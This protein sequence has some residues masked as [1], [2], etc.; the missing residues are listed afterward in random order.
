VLQFPNSETIFQVAVFDEHGESEAVFAR[1]GEPGELELPGGIAVGNVSQ[2][3]VQERVARPFISTNPVAGPRQVEIF[4]E[5]LTIAPPSIESISATAVTSSSATLRARI[6]PNNRATSFWFEYGL[7]DC[8]VSVCTKVPLEGAPLGEGRRGVVVS[9]AIGGLSP[10]TTYHIRAVAENDLGRVEG[11][12]KVFTTQGGT[13][14]F[15]LSDSRVW[16]M[17]SPPRKF[18]GTVV[19][20]AIAAIQASH[21]GD[22]L[23]YASRGPIVEEPESNR[24]VDIATVLGKRGADGRWSTTDLTPRHTVASTAS[25]PTAYQL[26]SPDLAKA[27]LEPTDKT[28]LS[29]DA[30]EETPY[31]WTD[32]EPPLFTPLVNPSNVP[33]GTEF[34]S[35]PGG[36]EDLVRLEGGSPDLSHIVLQSEVPL[37]QGAQPGSIYMWANGQLKPLSELPEEEGGNV[38]QAILGSG[39]GSVRHAVSEDGSRVFWAPTHEY[40][41]VGNKLPK[42]FMRDTSTE[43]TSRLDVVQPGASGSGPEL[44]AFNIASGDGQVV[45]F[46]DSQQLTED[47]SPNGRDLYRC[48]IGDVAG[49]LGC[50]DLTDISAPLQG[51]GESAEVPDQVPAASDDGSRVYFVARAILDETQNDQGGSAEAGMP[52]LYVWHEGQGVQFIATL[53]KRDYLVWGG[54]GSSNSVG[55]AERISAAA[56][57]S[58]RFFAFT[59]DRSLT[60]YENHNEADQPASEVFV[61]DAEASGGHLTCLSCNPTGAAAVGQRIPDST[62]LYPP[63]RGELWSGKWV[64]ATLPEAST[65]RLVGRS[66]YHPRTALDNGRVFFN[67][68]EAL[69][70][71][72]SN[73]DWDV[74]QYQPVGLGTCTETSNSATV[75][76]VHEGCVG[77]VSSGSTGGDVGFL[78]A[79]ASGN[80][81]FFLSRA[82]LSALDTD[83]E[84]DVYDARVDGIAV[85]RNLG[86]E[87]AGEACRPA[88]TPPAEQASASESFQGMGTPIVCRKG[89]R[90][91]R[92]N[93]KTLCVHRRHNKHKHHH[94]RQGSKTGR[95]G[96]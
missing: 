63:D 4:D 52:N 95:A 40:D 56:S 64:A 83:D 66:F 65:S 89:Q 28:P 30:S 75:S 49:S 7:A 41:T 13:L 57:P 87:C 69:V 9:Q 92:K 43:V 37:S 36:K 8:S 73:G 25:V 94:K 2:V 72:D 22:K 44:P 81:A 53:A 78:D 38:V 6:N 17:V 42:L 35:K 88:L 48:E 58:G 50:A 31:L 33:A 91:V 80:D 54:L 60:D 23:V 70:P 59:S 10:E 29:P 20:G 3:G 26:F 79:S 51:S 15:S 21:S 32:G 68:V 14:G 85:E 93:G 12:D 45:F 18:A 61:Y 71:A 76:R 24:L 84:F 34:G 39:Q 46:T 55:F 90:K 47:A 77:L 11:P 19:S 27:G 74:Y 96:R 67:S 16:E 62:F 5:E 86:Q 1:S 82:R